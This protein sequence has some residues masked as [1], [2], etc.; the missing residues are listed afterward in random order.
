MTHKFWGWEKADIRAITDE[1]RGIK[2]PVELYDA[3]SDRKS[4]V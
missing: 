2:T 3:L 4:V 1:Y